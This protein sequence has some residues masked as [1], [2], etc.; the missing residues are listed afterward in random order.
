M[1]G[2]GF[3]IYAGEDIPQ[4]EAAAKDDEVLE[5]VKNIDNI[6]NLNA[7]WK[8]LTTKQ[9][10]TTKIIDAFKN[11]KIEIQQNNVQ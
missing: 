4:A 8:D 7:Y 3:Y 9:R 6:L 5:V 11:Q 1:F 2:L 10:S